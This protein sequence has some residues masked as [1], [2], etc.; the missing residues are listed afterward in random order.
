MYITHM[1]NQNYYKAILFSCCCRRSW[2]FVE[3]F[4]HITGLHSEF[5]GFNWQAMDLL[6]LYSLSATLFS[7]TGLNALL[8]FRGSQAT[9]QSVLANPEAFDVWY[10]LL[11]YFCRSLDSSINLCLP[12]GSNFRVGSSYRSISLD[13]QPYCWI[14]PFRSMRTNTTSVNKIIFYLNNH[15]MP[16][17]I[18]RWMCSTYFAFSV[19]GFPRS[20]IS[21]ESVWFEPDVI[22]RSFSGL[23]LDALN[24]RE[25]RRPTVPTQ[26]LADPDA[27][28]VALLW[29]RESSVTGGGDTNEKIN[30]LRYPCGTSWFRIYHEVDHWDLERTRMNLILVRQLNFI[31]AAKEVGISPS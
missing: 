19:L 29:D 6:L 22:S 17:R 12:F 5:C 28:S 4:W 25:M 23:R 11:W 7:R 10:P 1:A 8:S 9:I 31:L 16:I 18:R 21:P 20:Y 26:Y 30:R 3:G 15:Q 13:L 27:A 24:F 14:G 2:G